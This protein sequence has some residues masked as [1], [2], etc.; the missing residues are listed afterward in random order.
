MPEPPTSLIGRRRDVEE[1]VHRLRWGGVRLLTLTGPGGVGK[2]RVALAATQALRRD[3][4]GGPTYVSL[5]PLRDAR[6][7]T[8]TMARELGLR[9]AGGG[10]IEDLLV[11]HLRERD[12]IVVLDNFEHLTE[13]SALLSS[14][15]QQCPQL[16]LLVTSRSALRLQGEHRMEIAPLEV[17]EEA[18][19]ARTE[20]A[21]RYPAVEL[22]AQRAQATRRD[23]SVRE[24][25]LAPVVEICRRLDGLPLAIEL[26]AARIAHLSPQALLMRLSRRLSL[27]TDGP[28]DL[29]ARQQTMRDTI[30][31]SYDLLDESE[32]RLLRHLA[33]FAGG[34]TLEAAEAVCASSEAAA[35]SIFDGLNAL[36]DQS[37]VTLDDYAEDEPRYRMLE[38]IR[39]FAGEQLAFYKE[40]QSGRMAHARYFLA[41]AEEAEPLLTGSEQARW[42]ESLEIEHDNLRVALDWAQ[43][44]G[45]ADLGLRLSATLWRFWFGHGHTDEGRRR[46]QTFLPMLEQA[47]SLLVQARVL[48]A[49]GALAFGLAVHDEA[50]QHFEGSLALYRTLGDSTHVAVTLNGLGVIAS[51]KGEYERALT[52]LRESAALHREAGN[53]ALL[54]APLMNTANIVR[55]QGRDAAAMAEAIALYEE[56]SNIYRR[57]GNI[58]ALANGLNNLALVLAETGDPERAI[59]LTDESI[60]LA[61]QLDNPS[62]RAFA[63]TARCA[64]ALDEGEDER[65]WL[66]AAEGLELFRRAGDRDQIAT[67]LINL[68]A[69][70]F[71][72]GR[73]DRAEELARE[74]QTLL[75]Q[76]GARRLLA[77]V[78]ENLGDVARARGDLRQARMQ[79]EESLAIRTEI[80]YV[81]GNA[82]ALKRLASLACAEGSWTLAAR[83]YGMAA[84]LRER[85]G[86]PMPRVQQAEAERDRARIQGVLGEEAFEA[87][88]QEGV[89]AVDSRPPAP[90]S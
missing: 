10:R 33:V 13:A 74:A 73:Y 54:A 17:P 64:I 44:S 55:Y 79:Y 50:R 77:Y 48:Y 3:C 51:S 11:E 89:T 70:E 68:G 7:V 16:R 58:S 52:H 67:T 30:A 15:L 65:A 85:L 66:L 19:L 78:F 56:G 83:Q 41:L 80:G 32:Q 37:L 59:E 69:L 8:P 57:I 45:D 87:A 24:D 39:E 40:E 75:Q 31:W 20:L 43:T 6:L 82:D 29:P 25:N 36:I 86:V 60:A 14:L 34:W 9:E 71:R 22:F 81:V 23:F 88:W 27:L 38:T 61:A 76:S 21:A 63:L 90:A 47:S 18:E 28:T 35:P 1:A 4:P 12:A 72:R 42:L 84:A 53:D 62:L 26:A 2:T 46:I 5:A 49:A